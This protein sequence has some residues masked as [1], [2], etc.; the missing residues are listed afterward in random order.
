ML[1][2]GRV[3]G[4]LAGNIDGSILGGGVP[5]ALAGL[6]STFGLGAAELIGLG[7]GETSMPG[8]KLALDGASLILLT[9]LST[10]SS[11]DFVRLRTPRSCSAASA[12]FSRL[13]AT[14]GMGGRMGGARLTEPCRG[15]P[16]LVE[17]RAVS[18]PNSGEG[19]P[20]SKSITDGE[21]GPATVEAVVEADALRRC[22]VRRGELV[23]S[24]A[25]ASL[26]LR[27]LNMLCD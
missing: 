13:L 10:T 1:S 16:S 25:A 27:R 12:S 22:G 18:R 21:V 2:R 19:R 9:G 26:A 5:A 20:K 23:G 24:A 17:G 14:R 15:V 7:N 4:P 6:A 8:S 11:S 3:E